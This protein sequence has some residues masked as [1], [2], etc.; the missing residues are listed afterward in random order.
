M[1][2]GSGGLWGAGYRKPRRSRSE[3]LYRRMPDGRGGMTTTGKERG[4]GR[5][6]EGEEGGRGGQGE[7]SQQ[8]PPHSQPLLPRR[9]WWSLR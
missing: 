1:S 5:G 2:S 6:G 8:L 4:R 9:S 3:K 7:T